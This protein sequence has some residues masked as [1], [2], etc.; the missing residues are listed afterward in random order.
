MIS[1]KNYR[2]FDCVTAGDTGGAVATTGSGQRT[3]ANPEFHRQ[4]P[5]AN[6][7][8]QMSTLSSTGVRV[9]KPDSFLTSRAID[10][11]QAGSADVVDLI[12]YVCNLPGAPRVVAEHLAHAMFDGRSEFSR[13]V[14]GRWSFTTEQVVA[15]ARNNSAVLAHVVNAIAF[16]DASS[17][18]AAPDFPGC[19][20]GRVGEM[21]NGSSA[22]DSP[23]LREM[24]FVVVDTETTGT[25]PQWGHRV[26]EVAAVVVE[27]GEIVEV[28][29]SLINPQ[30]PISSM[31]TALTGISWE[32]VKD[33]PVF[34][35]VSPR[36]EALLDGR[37]FV[38]HNAAFD[39]RFLQHEISRAT[40][41]YIEGPKL[42][43]VKLARK[44]LPTLQRRS[45]DHVAMF[46]GVEIA[47]RHR[48]AG[49]AIATAHCL[50]Y[51]L[52]RAEDMGVERW[53]DLQKL[54]R[55]RRS[56]KRKKRPSAMPGPI[57]KDTTA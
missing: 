16:A 23:R 9:S 32:M 33:A 12:S 21:P 6:L 8:T 48:A 35:E 39:W 43:T 29:E 7:R 27:R 31:I 4:S 13:G 52:R 46:C 38:A 5:V 40:G 44:V 51:M 42:C 18:S 24:S 34:R 55:L 20:D 50:N 47:S 14:D 15:K 36:V 45:L 10:F 56:T 54:M 57:A 22:A 30:R 11:L 17:H 25:S 53:D 26:T 19:D 41:R 28:F 3:A 2:R 49:D 37:V 1:G